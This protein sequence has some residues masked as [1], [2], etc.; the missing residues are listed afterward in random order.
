MR[1]GKRKAEC[2]QARR[3]MLGARVPMVA[4]VQ[5]LAVAEH[6]S[7]HRAAMALGTSQSSVSARIKAL[8]EELGICLFD[9]NTRGVRLTPAGRRFVDK[10]DAAVGVLE[11][12]I[13][14]AG[15]QARSEESEIAVG[16]HA[17]TQGGFLDK[18]LVR[19]RSEHPGVR[20]NITEATA[21]DAQIMLREGQLDLAFM[22]C[23]HE[24]A[25]LNSRVIWC[26]R[27]MAA[28]PVSHYLARESDVTWRQLAEE[29]FLVRRG[30]TGPQVG[31]LVVMRSAGR[32]P[33]PQIL[34]LDVGRDALFAMIAA[35]QGVSLFVEDSVLFNSDTITVL[36]VRDEQE[37][38][39]FSA[40]WSP[41]SCDPALSR[42]LAMA[43]EMGARF[44]RV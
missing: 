39:A 13:S 14:M 23:T 3:T 19:F 17:L 8:E 25:D 2:P 5:T 22:A 6:L 44:G 31:D 1:R 34:R 4:L 32:W 29:T 15:M 10:V 11:E 35:G 38:V 26:D 18:L 16:V 20:L 36:P 27:L 30:G 24:L 28:L 42:L 41:R 12:A 43:T 40:V 33:R 9:R 37:T 21:R 7:F